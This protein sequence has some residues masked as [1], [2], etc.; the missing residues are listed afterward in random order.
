M[1]ASH[2]GSPASCLDRYQR[3]QCEEVWLELTALGATIRQEPVFTD[4]L[5]VA[6]ETMR[7]IHANLE[8]LIERLQ[9]LGYRFACEHDDDPY[10]PLQLA[11]AA[12]RA[13]IAQAEQ[14]YGPLPVSVRVFYETI[15]SVDLRG[16]HPKL[17][18]YF[19][20]DWPIDQGVDAM[21]PLVVE[22]FDPMPNTVE[23]MYPAEAA[24]LG[25]FS[26]LW[27]MPDIT[28]KAGE[29]G[30]RSSTIM[31]PNPAMDAHFLYGDWPGM[32]F[33]SYLRLSLRWGG[34]ARFSLLPVAAEGAK[35]ERA[36]L[37]SGLLPI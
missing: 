2:Q 29:S 19:A 13:R 27:V 30:G 28:M 16:F 36:L 11:S 21:D 10:P 18:A 31:F 14:V 12:D 8:L 1:Q 33:M 17:N 22:P 25:Q 23:G 32:L 20:A 24:H 3:G 35:T 4:A 5:A 9:S 6:H 34:F 37:T 7:R 15:A 26:S